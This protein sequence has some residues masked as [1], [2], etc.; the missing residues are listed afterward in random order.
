MHINCYAAGDIVSRKTT[1]DVGRLNGRSGGIAV[2]YNCYFNSEALQKQGDTVD[3]PAVAVGVNANDSALLKNVSG[4]TK[5]ELGS[6]AFAQLLND[7]AAR[8][9]DAVA[10]V[11]AY[12]ETLQERGFV[13]KN[14]YTGNDLLTWR[15]QDGVAG[16]FA[17]PAPE[18]PF[19][20]VAA[21]SWYYDDVAYVFAKGIMVGTGGGHF[22]PAVATTRGV[23]VTMLYEY[24]RYK[25]Y[26]VTKAA[27]LSGFVD[28]GSV[29][30]FA[31]GP[32][33]WAV[34]QELIFG[35]GGNAI[36]P[37]WLQCCTVFA[38]CSPE[39]GTYIC[40]RHRGASIRMRPCFAPHAEKV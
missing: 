21:G 2:D 20:D 10:E 23:V 40:S 15:A 9:A 18:L 25:G 33:Q 37:S 34:A 30:D 24:A 3:A 5:A 14:D 7:N 31:V 4:K 22:S 36:A 28:Q 16:F 8:M 32:M 11:N 12:L 26:D 19:D 1:T 38:K 39:P 27:D 35:V 29:S 6:D 13:H 17:E